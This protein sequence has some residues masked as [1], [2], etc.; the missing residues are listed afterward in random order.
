MKT[1]KSTQ[2]RS[3][4]KLHSQ[5][6]KPAKRYLC[7]HSAQ[8][9]NQ[10]PSFIEI[11]ARGW[12]QPFL[13][14]LKFCL[15][16]PWNV[17]QPNPERTDQAKKKNHINIGKVLFAPDC[18]RSKRSSQWSGHP[19][20]FKVGELIPEWKTGNQDWGF[21]LGCKTEL[22]CREKKNHVWNSELHCPRNFIKYLFK[23]FLDNN[24]H[25]Y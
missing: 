9:R 8:L 23:I 13:W 6:P 11:P 24:G 17:L 14:G 18:L 10:D 4:K 2:S 7:S 12:L 25:S 20:R 5:D 19:Q 16:H 1:I 22:W 21:R 15:Y 3:S